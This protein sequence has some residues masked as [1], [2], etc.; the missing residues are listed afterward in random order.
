MTMNSGYWCPIVASSEVGKKPLART[1]FGEE[2]VLWRSDGRIVCMQDRC[3]HRSA[4]LSLGQVNSSRGTLS[5]PFHGLE[6]SA[7]GACVNV[8]VE[9][10]QALCSEYCVPSFQVK[11]A[12]GYVWIWR[13]P[14]PDEWPEFPA[15]PAMEG[16]FYGET[17]SIWPAHYTRCIENVCD[18][19]HLPFVHKTTI[20]RGYRD[21]AVQIEMEDVDGGFRAHLIRNSGRSRYFEFLYPNLWALVLAKRMMSTS[22][23]APIDENRTAVYGRIYYEKDFPGKKNLMNVWARIAQFLIFREDWPIVATQRPRDVRDAQQEKL[24]PSDAPVIAY[25]K[26]HRSFSEL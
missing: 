3:P 18:Y 17:K 25:R 21:P 10:D 9:T 22:V 19:S 16:L 6:F 1:R 8:P 26:L 12:N 4:A 7:D 15:H 24:L 14:E 20:G 11:E 23:F 13:G 2:L 5:C